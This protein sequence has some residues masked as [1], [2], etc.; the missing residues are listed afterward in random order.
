MQQKELLMYFIKFY[1][2]Q[3]TQGLLGKIK[4]LKILVPRKREAQPELVA[5]R[6]K[7]FIKKLER[8]R[9]K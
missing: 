8:S 6:I 7:L 4:Q 5:E 1:D 9:H 3:F 2:C